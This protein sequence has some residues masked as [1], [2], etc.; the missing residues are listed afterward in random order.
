MFYFLKHNLQN[1]LKEVISFDLSKF[2]LTF[3]MFILFFY[4]EVQLRQCRK[5]SIRLDF[6]GVDST[7]YPIHFQSIEQLDIEYISFEPR[8]QVRKKH[9]IN[10][11]T[12]T[13]GNDNSKCV[14]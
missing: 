12:S 4:R 11:I 7:H 13:L 14:L 8:Y 10:I 2:F 3:K 6:T 1:F 5:L 9:S